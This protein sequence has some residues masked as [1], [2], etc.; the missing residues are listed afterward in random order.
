MTASRLADEL[1]NWA[2]Q[3]LHNS[4]VSMPPPDPRSSFRVEP[5]SVIAAVGAIYDVYKKI[6]S[7]SG[8]GSSKKALKKISE[9]LSAILSEL[10]E[11]RKK[12]DLIIDQLNRIE[13]KIDDQQ[14]LNAFSDLK[15]RCQIISEN[16][17]EWSD[18]TKVEELVFAN[19]IHDS[20]QDANRRLSNTGRY[21]FIFDLI[22][23]FL[24]ELNMALVLKR[25]PDTVSNSAAF[26]V[27]YLKG[28]IDPSNSSS[29]RSLYLAARA[30]TDRIEAWQSSLVREEFLRN[31][32]ITTEEWPGGHIRRRVEVWRVIKGTL[33][34]G[35]S[36]SEENRWTDD[37]Y[38]VWTPGKEVRFIASASRALEKQAVLDKMCQEYLAQIWIVEFGDAAIPA[39]ERAIDDIRLRATDQIA[40]D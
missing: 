9:Q 28:S 13:K 20:L 37:E 2:N 35:F 1:V 4:E 15:S 26:M 32:W 19:S 22:Y 34:T 40:L 6:S 11:I 18:A 3:A 14:A 10:S 33:R 12:L 31:I 27:N 25:K 16:F 7:I 5:T 17:S 8:A 23:S 36:F 38:T 29:I 21:N 30:I 39:V 24:M